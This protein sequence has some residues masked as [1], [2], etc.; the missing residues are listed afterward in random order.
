MPAGTP[1]LR[2]L[3]LLAPV[4]SKEVPLTWLTP[5]PVLCRASAPPTVSAPRATPPVVSVNVAL[6][7]TAMDPAAVWLN[8]SVTVRLEATLKVPPVW[9]RL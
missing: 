5:P 6:P 4:T 9:V 8:A 2:A 7:V 3:K 1:L